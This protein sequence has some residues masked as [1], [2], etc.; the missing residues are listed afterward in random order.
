MGEQLG[1]GAFAQVFRGKLENNNLTN[2]AIKVI[3]IKAA[4][5]PNKFG[6][7]DKFSYYLQHEV[8]ILHSIEHV[9]IVR[10]HDFIQTKNNFYLVFECCEGGDLSK[11]LKEHGPMSEEEA[12]RL[13]Y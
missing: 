8:D 11:Y 12:Q 2:F 4:I 3:D 5:G 9:N 6:S 1:K 7:F 10:L 13:M